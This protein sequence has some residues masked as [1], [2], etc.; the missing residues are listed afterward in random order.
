MNLEVEISFE[1]LQASFATERTLTSVKSVMSIERIRSREAFGANL[2]AERSVG[3][4]VTLLWV[5]LV[6]D[7]L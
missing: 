5:L 3:P 4:Y 7:L 6:L 1:A 2:A